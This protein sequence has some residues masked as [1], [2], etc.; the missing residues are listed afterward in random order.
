MIGALV[1]L[2]IWVAMA[3][4]VPASRNDPEPADPDAKPVSTASGT[5]VVVTAHPDA[6]AAA[7]S[8]LSDGGQPSMPWSQPKQC[9]RWLNPKALALVVGVSCCT[10]MRHIDRWRCW[11]DVRQLPSAANRMIC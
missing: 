4:A 8:A 7:L 6:S 1:P 3:G 11:T 5:A 2:A 10:G 9:W